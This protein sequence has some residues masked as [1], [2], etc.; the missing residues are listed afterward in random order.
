M[1]PSMLVVLL[2]NVTAFVL[3]YAY[4][5]G[6]RCRLLALETEVSRRP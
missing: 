6:R 5:A 3:T 1:D 2:V 4:L